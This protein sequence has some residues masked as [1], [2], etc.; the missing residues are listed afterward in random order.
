MPVNQVKIFG[1]RNT[2]TNLLERALR[3]ACDAFV[4][5]GNLPQMR[6]R[7]HAMAACLAPHDLAHRLIEA[8]RD[9][10]FERCFTYSLGWKHARVPEPR[11]GS[12]YPEE[13]GFVTIRKNPYSWLLSLHRR[14]YS[15]L[16]GKLRSAASFGEFLRMAWPTVS[17]EN[18]PPVYETPI[19][20]WCDKVASYGKLDG[21]R[22]TVHVRYEDILAHPDSVFEQIDR[23]LDIAISF[24]RKILDEA[25]K[26]DGK[27]FEDFRSYYLQ[28]RWREKLDAE[29]V[30]F[31]NRMLD[32]VV[33]ASSGYCLIDPAE[34]ATK[35]PAPD[36]LAT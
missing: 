1:E 10:F 5:P 28:E 7:V 33:V 34:V 17:R 26:R 19:H 6:Q 29:S 36:I 8:D 4:Y 9:R 32:P 31:I 18:A 35:R 16:N 20:L 2:G 12:T 22:P 3:Q 25:T 13:L 30:N 11:A 27:H 23:T 24:D 15:V 14:P 21:L